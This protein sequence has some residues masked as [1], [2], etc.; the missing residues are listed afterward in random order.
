TLWF[1][2]VGFL[3][4]Q[5]LDTPVG[6]F[7]IRQMGI[8][9][10]FGLLA[11]IASLAFGDLV[12]KIVVA[13]GIFF[14]GVA[15]FTRKIKTVAP[16]AHL[17][18]FIKKFLQTTTTTKHKHSTSVKGKSSV[19]LAS[20][21]ML[22]SA[23]LGAPVKVVG[24]LKDFSGKILSGKNFKVNVNNTA[25][26]NGATDQEGYF[27]TYFTPDHPGR[28]QIDIQPEDSQETIQQI[29]IQ[30]NPKT[31]EVTQNAQKTIA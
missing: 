28:F 17:L 21:S 5:M 22:L 4:E 29:T 13:G 16:E 2:N 18:Y 6:R 31:E 7:S 24:V 9:L 14:T 3:N 30:V 26:S 20:R 8:F 10:I 27:C 19:E 12:F 11:W 15:L 1:E 25:H 23:T